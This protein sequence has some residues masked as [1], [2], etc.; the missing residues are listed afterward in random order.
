M[1]SR[2]L[3]AG[4]LGGVTTFSLRNEFSTK[5]AIVA[6]VFVLELTTRNPTMTIQSNMPPPKPLPITIQPGMIVVSLEGNRPGAIKGITQGYCV[7]SFD[8][9]NVSVEPWKNL[10]VANVCPAAPLLPSTVSDNDRLNAAACV[11]RELSLLKSLS[12]LTPR[13]TAAM[14]ELLVLLCPRQEVPS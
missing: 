4:R 14:E 2:A 6:A 1:A 9:Q 8:D 3:V 12:E 7:Y 10:A 5:A 11:L 13:Q